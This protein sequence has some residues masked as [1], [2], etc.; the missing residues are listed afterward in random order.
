MSKKKGR[1]HMNMSLKK[2]AAAAVSVSMVMACVAGCGAKNSETVAKNEMLADVAK[3]EEIAALEHSTTAG[4]TETVYIIKNGDGTTRT[5]VSEWLKNPSGSASVK[6]VASLEG[7]EVVK[8]DATLQENENGNITWNAK[9]ADVFYS[10]TTTKAAP[11]DVE[12]TYTLDGAKIKATDLKGKSGHL[13]IDISYRN[14]M[15]KAVKGKD[16]KEHTIYMPFIMSTGL[17][18]ENSKVRNVTVENG[19][20]VNDGD[21]TIVMGIGFPG[22]YESLGLDTIDLNG[23]KEK[24]ETSQKIDIPE[25]IKIECDVKDCDELTA[26]TV[27]KIFDLKDIDKKV[28]TEKLGKDM[29]DMTDGMKKLID[30]SEDLREG[31]SKINSGAKTIHNG[32]KTLSDGAS[33][34]SKG[35]GKIAAGTKTLNKGA[36]QLQSNNDT[37]RK[38]AKAI[39][40]GLSAIDK[41]MP[42]AANAKALAD[43]SATVKKTI[44][45]MYA[46]TQSV[47][48]SEKD[49]AALTAKLQKLVEAGELDAATMKQM[50]AVYKSYAGL[51]KGVA[52]LHSGYG[53]INTAMQAYP[54]LA[55]GIGKAAKGADDLHKGINAYTAGVDELSSGIRKVDS[56]MAKLSTSSQQLAKGAKKLSNGTG[57]LEDGTSK[58]LNGSKELLSGLKKFDDKAVDRVSDMISDN[59]IPLTDRVE[60]LKAYADTY[61]SFAG[62]DSTVECSTVFV[63]KNV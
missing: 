3:A 38:G 33:A 17:I 28:D 21:H 49:I 19:E 27:G 62:T 46:V 55:S 36:A 29:D 14:S 23:K 16:G 56:G 41:K 61:K 60:S 22:L 13:V 1:I 12:L 34:L 54:V 47:S 35:A 51:E 53:N 63:F 24:D 30:G 20:S 10:G 44:D 59:L 26:L 31:V 37:L 15:S 5:I 25:N 7:I 4:K 50:I 48:V 39:D 40:D 11:V 57:T 58:L 18:L 43:G 52:G 8:G 42:S 2:F 45:S 32:A 9:G 6:D